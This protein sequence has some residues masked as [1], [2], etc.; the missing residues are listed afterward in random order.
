MAIG[1]DQR[2]TTTGL[3]NKKP[4]I[5]AAPDLSS[6]QGAQ[7]TQQVQPTQDQVTP[8]IDQLE[9]PEMTVV[10]QEIVKRTE[11]LTDEDRET[12]KSVLS[13]SVRE[14]FGKL[15]P[16]FSEVMEEFGTDEPNV[17]F[18]LSYIVKFAMTRYGG[19][20][21]QEAMN[22]FMTD[23]QSMN[24]QMEQPNNVPPGT[25]QPTETAGLM[26]SPQNMETV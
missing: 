21:E 2:T 3:V 10:E 8:P 26:S 4:M 17:I 5:P 11:S 7:Q 20:D 1:P 6:L 23:V 22:N 18:P 9:E 24:Q 25:E 15:L 19:Q 12:F 14:V 13:P 16:E